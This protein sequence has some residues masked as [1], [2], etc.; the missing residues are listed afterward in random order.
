MTSIFQRGVAIVSIDT[1]LMWGYSDTMSEGQFETQYPDSPSTHA[2]LLSR[3]AAAR[4]SATWFLV[5][6]LTR[7]DG[8]PGHYGKG[9][10]WEAA[11]FVQCL[12]DVSPT[13]EIA[14]HG[15]LTHLVWTHESMT[16]DIAE[17]ELKDGIEALS[18]ACPDPCSFSFPRNCEAFYDLLPQHGI[19]AYRGRPPAL[20]WKLGRN[21][22]GAILRALDEVRRAAPPAVMPYQ[23]IPGL[24]NIPASM[25][26]YP[27]GPARTRIVGLRSRVERFRLGI[28]AAARQRAIFHF[29]LHP[30]NLAESPHGV[31]LLDEILDVLVRARRRGDIEILTMRDVLHRLQGEESYVRE[32]QHQY[33]DLFETHRRG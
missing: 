20:S 31:F 12:R 16:R 24:W 11:A 23:A 29:C 2:R 10:L 17:R 6:A 14:V 1:E 5:G 33:S 4:V 26:L 13:Q 21:V 3:L 7:R 27:I 25:F 18:S 8:V 28:E 9:R 32:E 15:G 19:H 22:P 30:E